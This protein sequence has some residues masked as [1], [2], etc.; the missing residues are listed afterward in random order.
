MRRG[1]SALDIAQDGFA[2][3]EAG[4]FLDFPGNIGRY[5]LFFRFF[6][7]FSHHDNGIGFPGFGAV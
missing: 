2:G 7:S 4:V 5:P 1:P 6:D 3:L